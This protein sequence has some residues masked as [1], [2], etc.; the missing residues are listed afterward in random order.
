MPL[1]HSRAEL[2]AW[3]RLSLELGL[4]PAAAYPLLSAL[5]LPEQIYALG[6]AALARHVPQELAR[7]LAAPVS[8]ET[9]D[10]IDRT[11]DW[12]E[13]PGHH[14][15]TLADAAYPQSLL[16]TADPPLLLYVNGDTARLNTPALAVVGARSATPGV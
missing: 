10:Q 9:Q 14:V 13:Q 2:S 5:G 7:Q 4:G 15:L 16:T 8:S 6:A 11:L 3:L 12:V 1:T